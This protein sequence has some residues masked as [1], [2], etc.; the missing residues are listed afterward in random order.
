VPFFLIHSLI[1]GR[2]SGISIYTY[3]SIFHRIAITHHP[4]PQ[5]PDTDPKTNITMR[6][7]I[8]TAIMALLSFIS[9]MPITPSAPQLQKR[10]EQFRL[11][12]L[13]EV[14]HCLSFFPSTET[15]PLL[16]N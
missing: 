16:P 13:R 15:P 8:L 14:R 3:A 11:E 5:N 9:A 10:A 7:F 4:R 6:S 12:G 1:N 2:F